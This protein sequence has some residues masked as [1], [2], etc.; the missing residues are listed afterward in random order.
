VIGDD[1]PFDPMPWIE[2][3]KAILW[4]SNH[5]AGRLPVGT[6]LVWIKRN[7]DAFGTF[8]SDAEIAW[9]RGGYGVYCIKELCNESVNRMHPCQKP[10]SVMRW[11][12]RMLKLEPGSLILDPYMGS[13]TTLI[14]A[15][16]EGHRA[17]GVEIDPRYCRIAKRR[18]ERPHQ[19]FGRH[20]S[21]NDRDTPLF[22]GL[23]QTEET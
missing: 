9:M 19:P 2:V 14:A 18:I 12:I 3:P 4:G 16:A 5:F 8:L 10:L 15:L 13:G 21:G 22:A 23:M 20:D 11:C 17:I 7:D 6:T 1:K